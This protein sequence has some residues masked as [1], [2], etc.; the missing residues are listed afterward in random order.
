MNDSEN[1]YIIERARNLA[2]EMMLRETNGALSKSDMELC[3]DA[4]ASYG[5]AILAGE[6]V[7]DLDDLTRR[8]VGNHANETAHDFRTREI[9]GFGPT[10]SEFCARALDYY[11]CELAA[12]V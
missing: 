2:R 9:V 8:I 10:D 11:G 1:D 3:A 4:H 6:A 5:A 12:A 7:K